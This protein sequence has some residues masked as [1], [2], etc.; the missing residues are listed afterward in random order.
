MAQ[1]RDERSLGD[2]FSDLS[3]ETTTLVRQEVQLAKAELTQSA[4]EVAR[5][6]GMLVAG[7]AVAYAGLL[8]LLLAIV[9]GLIEAGWDAW[10]SALV[11]GLVVVA[12]GA[13]LVLRARESLKPANL[14]PQKTVETLKEDAAWAKEQIT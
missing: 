13:V 7:G 9:F 14:A 11:V 12:I 4:T 6:I 5:G 3:R 10:L 8:F 2:L 1:V